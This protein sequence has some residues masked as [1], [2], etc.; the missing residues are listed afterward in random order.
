[1]DLLEIGA[2]YATNKY[3]QKEVAEILNV[4]VHQVVKGWALY[5]QRLE[6]D[7]KLNNLFKNTQKKQEEAYELW[8]SLDTPNIEEIMVKMLDLLEVNT[9][10]K[11]EINQLKEKLGYV[12]IDNPKYLKQ[13]IINILKKNNN[14]MPFWNVCDLITISYESDKPIN[15]HIYAVIKNNP[16]TFIYQNSHITLK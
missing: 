8:L 3:T 2:F 13:A 7:K 11:E 10:L 1:M 4:K 9:G 12:E 6:E 14:N 16:D 15:N 5:Q